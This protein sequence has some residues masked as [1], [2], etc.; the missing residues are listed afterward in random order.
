M[1]IV[2]VVLAIVF[3]AALGLDHVVAVDSRYLK[4]TK[5]SKGTK[6]ISSSKKEA[7]SKKSK[8]LKGFTTDPRLPCSLTCEP[9]PIGC[10]VTY[11]SPDPI[12]LPPKSDFFPPVD[13]LARPYGPEP[14]FPANLTAEYEWWTSHVLA[15]YP[16]MIPQ[17]DTEWALTPKE[18]TLVKM[19][20]SEWMIKR[21]AGEYTCSELA[22]ALTKRALYFQHVQ[23]MNH[24]MYWGTFDWIKVVLKEAKSLDKLAKKHGND[25]LA[26]LY[27]YPIPLKGTVCKLAFTVLFANQLLIQILIFPFLFSSIS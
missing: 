6:S 18:V 17:S 16:K 11:C 24:F 23:H 12:L 21:S 27:C 3:L 1:K 8:S 10:K 25:A 15:E 19:E 5:S 7:K 14:S 13:I 26:P 4:G 22:K 20:L 2:V 9:C